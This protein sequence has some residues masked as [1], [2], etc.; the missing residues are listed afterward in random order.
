MWCIIHFC[1]PK[2]FTSSQSLVIKFVM[3]IKLKSA[4]KYISPKQDIWIILDYIHLMLL[5]KVKLIFFLKKK[6][7]HITSEMKNVFYLVP[8][9]YLKYLPGHMNN[10]P[11]IYSSSGTAI[12]AYEIACNGSLCAEILKTSLLKG[13]KSWNIEWIKGVLLDVS[14]YPRS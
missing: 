7:K 12:R 5:L 4:L 11:A 1:Y 13:S 8:S 6:W 9:L 2:H 14:Q 10:M 3:Y